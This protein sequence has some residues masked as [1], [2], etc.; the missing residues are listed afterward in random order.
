ML[1][2]VRGLEVGYGGIRAV[3]G[4]DLE[5]DEGELVCLIGANG[6]GKSS[7]LKAICGL[8]GSHSGKVIYDENEI[9]R[10]PIHERPRRGLVM[11][12]CDRLMVLD[13]G[14]K[15]AE[16]APAEVQKDARVIEAYLG[17]PRAA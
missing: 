13:Y 4:I 15:I 11:N 6:A 17:R 2:E 16:G 8:V 5:V 3:K 10:I 7:T 14:E 12:V 9:S 1:L